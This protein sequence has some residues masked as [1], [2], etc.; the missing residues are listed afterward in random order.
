M[1]HELVGL[2]GPGGRWR[3]VAAG[4]FTLL[5]VVLALLPI[6]P[7]WLWAA[8]IV[9]VAALPW[10]LGASPEARRRR[11]RPYWRLSAEGLE[12]LG[13]GGLP[14]IRYERARV[15]GLAVTTGDNVLTV[16]HKFGRT[17]IGTLDSMGFEPLP[18]F[19]T[20]RRL[21]IPI[22]L[23][24]GDA[25]ELAEAP[26]PS[27]DGPGDLG[28]PRHQVAEQRLLDQEAKLL[29]AAHE[30][31]R[32][33]VATAEPAEPAVAVESSASG[34]D[35]ESPAGPAETPG[36]PANPVGTVEL[37][38]AASPA[39]REPVRLATPEPLPSRRRVVALGVLTVLLGTIMI[40]RIAVEGTGGF[41][42]RLAAAC[43]ALAAIGAVLL[44][45]RRLL[46]DARIRWTISGDRLEVRGVPRTRQPVRLPAAR[47][48]ALVIGP[49][50]RPDPLTGEPRRAD[51][52]VLAFDHR[53]RLVARLPAH[54]LDTFQ[55]AHALDDHGYRV[56]TPGARQPRTPEYGL[57]GLPEIFAQVPGGR[58][59]V[60]DGGLGWADAAG[61]VVLRM[62]EDRI[63]GIELLT[64]SGHAW[65]RLYDS[66]GD[67][68]FAAPLSTLRIARTDLRES[69][70]RAGLPVTDAEYDAYLSAAFH[71]AVATLSS[72]EPGSAV[73][74][75]EGGTAAQAE[76]AGPVDAPGTL[77]DATRRSRLG[78][79]LVSVLL[80]ELVALLGAIWLGP[81]VG[82]FTTAASWSVPSGVLVGLG[83]YWLYDRNRSQLRVSAAGLA[84]VTRRGRVEWDLARDRVGGVG[85]DE[86]GDRMPRLVV[87]SPAGRVLRQVGFPP[88]LEELRRACERYGLPWGP[89]DAD[90]PAPPPPEL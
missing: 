51:P 46:R 88:D 62:P 64:I 23:L 86:T 16:L 66:D 65:V 13:P 49:G 10:A 70:R 3:P 74:P 2:R 21:G 47:I 39:P 69:A 84:V 27:G 77:L 32:G 38:P 81:D 72:P 29:A 55:L 59:V 85:I 56:I 12:R 18:L 67:E 22:H 6:R 54:G 71:S 4:P 15:E 5:A 7:V 28:L 45:R 43:W 78:T 25:A 89:P 50:L 76:R 14:M 87:W 41:G 9:A 63:G 26:V 73:P 83:G 82:G 40:A 37:E 11:P 48:A 35:A 53:L 30:P 31:P 75:A 34:K 19:V 61:D 57:D 17:P 8:L 33:P 58:L 24:D 80:C 68:F 60:A 44:A 79:Y 52:A 90:R 20:A 1:E 36:A 42:A